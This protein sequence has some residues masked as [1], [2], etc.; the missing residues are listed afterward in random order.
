M[1]IKTIIKR[2]AQEVV[3]YLNILNYT[4]STLDDYITA[5]WRQFRRRYNYLLIRK[6][7]VQFLSLAVWIHVL[8][9][10]CFH[11]CVGVK[12]DTLCRLR[13]KKKN[14]IN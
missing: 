8:F 6:L 4:H 14:S 5:G 7:G 3:G 9:L 11:E 13:R 10:V 1:C 12:D 2:F